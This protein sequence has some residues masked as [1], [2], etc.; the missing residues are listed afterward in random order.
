V[1]YMP[2]NAAAEW[3]RFGTEWM[4]PAQQPEA[5]QPVV[6]QGKGRKVQWRP[7]RALIQG[8][9]PRESGIPEDVLAAL[10]DFAFHEAELRNLELQVRIGES[11]MHE[12]VNRAYKIRYRDRKNWPR[13]TEMIEY[14]S[15]LIL[16]F[17][18]LE[19]RLLK[20]SRTLPRLARRWVERLCAEADIEE[21]LE[22]LDDRLVIGE[23]LYEG[24]SDR[25]S[26]YKGYHVGHVLEVIIVLFLILEVIVM[27]LE[28]KVTHDN[29]QFEQE[30][31]KYEKE[32]AEKDK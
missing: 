25:V 6:I 12:D 1:I 15:R 28:L 26:D 16:V 17:A 13:F 23:A 14:F 30:R 3:Q 9:R 20:P 2:K 21:R 7:G 8:D 11:G 22:D 27:G 32:Q 18:Q 10:I 4:K 29:H 24:A 19:P 31:F 5:V